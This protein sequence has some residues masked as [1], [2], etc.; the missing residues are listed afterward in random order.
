M[1]GNKSGKSGQNGEWELWVLCC[2]LLHALFYMLERFGGVRQCWEQERTT[3][4]GGY[5][6]ATCSAFLRTTV[7]GIF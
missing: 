5:P 7:R 1:G 4:S 2:V 3:C 6:S